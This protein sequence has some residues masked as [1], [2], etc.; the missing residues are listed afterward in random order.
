MNYPHDPD[1]V[2]QGMDALLGDEPLDAEDQFVD[3][4]PEDCAS[5][6]H[7]VSNNNPSMLI[8]PGGLCL[9]CY[10]WQIAN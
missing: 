5:C 8:Y 9:D 1:D 10:S 7:P 4:A 3:P 2:A 6:G